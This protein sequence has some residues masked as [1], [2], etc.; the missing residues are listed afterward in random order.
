MEKLLALSE[1]VGVGDW[2]LELVLELVLMKV[3]IML[4]MTEPQR[5]PGGESRGLRIRRQ[6][7]IE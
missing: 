1:D 5:R 2:M 3:M 6:T 4:L 7:E